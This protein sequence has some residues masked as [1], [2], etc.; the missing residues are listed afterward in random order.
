MNCNFKRDQTGLVQ[1]PYMFCG[2]QCINL[3]KVT[4]EHFNGF[5]I[6]MEK[7]K[8]PCKFGVYIQT[9]LKEYEHFVGH[10]VDTTPQESPETTEI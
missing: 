10:I 7:P 9:N 5:R 3:A 1:I 2:F 8:H 4:Y 6:R